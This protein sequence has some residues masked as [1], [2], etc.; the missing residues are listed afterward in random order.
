MFIDLGASIGNISTKF[1]EENPEFE[2]FAFEVNKALE[3]RL[4]AVKEPLGE[5]FHYYMVASWIVN[6]YVRL[7]KTDHY[8]ASTILTGKSEPD[9]WKPIDYDA[10]ESVPCIDVSSWIAEQFKIGDEIVL[11]M[12]VEGAEYQIIQKLIY[13]G[14][15]FRLSKLIC[16]WRA[17]L[18]PHRP[19]EEHDMTY[20]KAA[21]CVPLVDWV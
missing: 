12:D 11:K 10:Y 19:A 6:G 3:S 18:F 13:D 2:I 15:I 17:A 1:A 8:M 14:M 20:S 4:A 5:R 9:G 16:E 7:D 21:K